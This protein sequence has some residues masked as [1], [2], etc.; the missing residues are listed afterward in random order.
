[1]LEPSTKSNRRP[2]V[3][4]SH[5]LGGFRFTYSHLCGSLASHGVVVVA[6]EHRDG[7]APVSFIRDDKGDLVKTV[8][9]CPVSHENTQEVQDAR[10]EQ[11]RVRLWEMGLIHDLLAKLDAGLKVS[12]FTIAA[13]Q[14][15]ANSANELSIFKD[16][17]RIQEP[18]SIT[19]AGHSFGAATVVQF[20]KSVFY[21]PTSSTPSTYRPLY[22]PAENSAITRQI[23]PQSALA[24]LDI[25]M[26][27][28]WNSHTQWLREKP[29]PSYLRQEAST[30]NVVAIL[31]EGFFKW[32]VN[33]D[34]V[35][36][37]LSPDPQT[38]SS[39]PTTRPHIFYVATSAHLSQSDFGVLFPFVTKMALKAQEPERTLKLNVRAVL[40]AMRGNGIEVA[41]TSDV[42]MEVVKGEGKEEVNGYASAPVQDR[43]ILL[44]DGSVRGW[45][46]VG[47]HGEARNGN[48]LDKEGR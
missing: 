43:S 24:L 29:L 5:G 42:D 6:P 12:N 35:K 11:L 13:E 45:I 38:S 46:P 28:I 1:M 30:S 20:V 33:L 21:R 16:I 44:T 3:V 17:L 8:A 15:T 22:S 27:P 14:A 23:K 26:L 31:S 25:W 7:S 37:I 39:T 10:D 9:Y 2:V 47:L 36:A 19:W 41:D 48:G 32:Q 40:Q 34:R 18:G 4:F